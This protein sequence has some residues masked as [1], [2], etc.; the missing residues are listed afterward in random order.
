MSK[1]RQGAICVLIAA[2]F[3]GAAVAA[4]CDGT[5]AIGSAIMPGA[6]LTLG[7]VII[8][9]SNASAPVRRAALETQARR[10]EVDQAG[11]RLNPVIGVELENF[12][13]SGALS[14]FSETETTVSYE[15]TFE[16][17]NKRGYRQGLAS[18]QAALSNAECSA[19]LRQAELEAATLFYEMEAANRV[20]DFANDSAELAQ[21]LVDIV[22]KRVE[23]GA[24]AP[25]E[26]SRARADAVALAAAAENAKARVNA[27]R[28]EL[29]AMW[30]EPN[31]QFLA[32]DAQAVRPEM[33]SLMNSSDI[34]AHPLLDVA[35][36][37]TA[38]SQAAQ[39]LAQSQSMPNVTL[40]AGLRRFEASDDAALLF[41]VSVPF[42]IFDKNRDAVKA[43]GFRAQAEVL[44][45]QAIEQDLLSQ[46]NAARSQLISAQ[47][48][49]NLLETSA[50]IE[51]RSA[52]D[53]SVRGY[54]AGK[55]DLTS[56][57]NARKGL[58]DAGLAVIDA[59]LT[60]NI[61]DAKL[62]SLTGAA[63]FTGD[64]K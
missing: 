14:G 15:Q 59:R 58:I 44:N 28:Y 57:L 4:P 34:T 31:P 37:Q 54:E 36:A 12:A 2:A 38:L 23:A 29:A 7:A 11:R 32:P 56:T 61:Q 5:P 41:G 30:G 22:A 40:S 24:G 33:S 6:P 47:K 35:N 18:A 46:Q 64:M 53:A 1:Y 16:L 52:Y 20:A 19:I 63:P 8:E 25:P 10:A 51:A 62:R 3:S 26:L 49:L 55:F 60:V 39:E 21:R 50:L 13:G 27:L 43:S 42:P 48:Q 17:G 9:L 45:R